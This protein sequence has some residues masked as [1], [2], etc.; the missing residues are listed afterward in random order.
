M[1]RRYLHMWRHG[2]LT[3]ATAYKPTE[4]EEAIA[5][6]AY[7]P[8]TYVYFNFPWG[9]KG[10]I[11]EHEDGPDEWQITVLK[12]IA[13]GLPL[14]EAI[15]Q[16]VRS[17]HG[18]GKTALIAWI[19][20][21]FM[22]TRPH[23]QVVVTA[24]TKQQLESKT[25]RE[26]AK[27]H[28][29]SR[30][31]DWCKHTSTKFYRI[32]HESTWFASLVPWTKEKSEAFAGTHEDHVLIIYDEA[33]AIVDIIW[34]V[35]EGAMTGV[36]DGQAITKIWIAFGNPTKNT[37]RFSECFK[38]NRHRW[39]TMEIDSRTAK[40]SDKDEIAQW[41]DDW[42]LDSDFVRVRVLG[43][44]PRAGDMQFIPSDIVEP[45][46]GKNI[47]PPDYITFPKIMGV[48][49]AGDGDGSDMTVICKRQGPATFELIK[50]RGQKTGA[51][52]DRVAQEMKDWSPDACFIDIGFNPGV[53]HMLK[54][55]GYKVSEV[56]FGGA[57]L[58]KEHYRNKR[59]EMWGL[60]KQ[61]LA[62]G[63][64]IPRDN[65]LRD[66]LLGPEYGGG[67]NDGGKLLLESKKDMKKRGL[68]SPDCAD[69]LALTYARPVIKQSLKEAYR[70]SGAEEDEWSPLRG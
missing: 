40:K 58:D 60:M 31:K 13:A 35:T 5:S 12:K 62:T 41:I 36:S 15:R 66:D 39:D 11:L 51:I 70:R 67:T 8:L 21:W 9:V 57:P 3:Q 63:L 65:Q 34:D 37:G 30:T 61:A 44:E 6:F 52:A 33:S 26:L 19:I 69:A 55:W 54:D 38:K 18:I 49:V 28:N 20:K 1:R 16:A 14:N 47:A 43:Q 24:N 27:W 50:L 25:W 32:E 42:G 68:A 4:L 23:P 48:D 53:Y 45:N 56:Q 64:A 17:G 22:D 46:M 10:T 29:L 7:D 2:K 59:A